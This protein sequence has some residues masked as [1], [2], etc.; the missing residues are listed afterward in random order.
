MNKRYVYISIFYFYFNQF[1]SI[2]LYIN[3]RSGGNN[4]VYTLGPARKLSAQLWIGLAP[5][6][7]EVVLRKLQNAVSVVLVRYAG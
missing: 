6:T 7:K 5:T 2:Q 3:D 4:K 1:K